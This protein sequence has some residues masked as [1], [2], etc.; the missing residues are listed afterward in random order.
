MSRLKQRAV[1]RYLTFKNLSVAKIATEHQDV[2]GRDALKSSTV[3]KWRLR[4]QDGLGGLFDLTR[5]ERPSRSDLAAPIQSLVQQFPFISCK[6]LCCRLKIGKA[7]CLRVL[8]DDLHLAKFN[9]CYVSH[10]PEADQKRS[11]VELP[12]EL[13]QILVQDQQYKFEHI[14]TGDGSRLILNIFIIRAGPQIQIA[15]LKSQSRNSIRKCIISMI[16]GSTG[17][18]IL[19]FVPKGMKYNATFFVQSVVQDLVEQ[20][21]QDSPRKTV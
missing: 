9:L 16:W 15:G 13:L 21:C 5:S 10:S 17:I 19:M 18:N 8:H 2:Y 11:R 7:T 6:V 12:R 4:F 20:V 3:S 1:I 14:L